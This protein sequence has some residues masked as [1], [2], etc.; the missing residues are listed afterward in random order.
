M[1]KQAA[2]GSDRFEQRGLR[3]RFVGAHCS[4]ISDHMSLQ[5]PLKIQENGLLNRF[6]CINLQLVPLLCTRALV[7]VASCIASPPRQVARLLLADLLHYR[8]PRAIQEWTACGYHDN[9]C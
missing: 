9:V 4:L 2:Q 3:D 1:A 8:Q 5:P 6:L 7:V